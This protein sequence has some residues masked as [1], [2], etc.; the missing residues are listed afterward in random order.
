MVKYKT[1]KKSTKGNSPTGDSG[2]T[3]LSPIGT[4]F[5]VY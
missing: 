1:L 3:S 4:A 2:P 5:L